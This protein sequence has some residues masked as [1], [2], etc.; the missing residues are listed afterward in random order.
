MA[1]THTPNIPKTVVTVTANPNEFQ[2]YPVDLLRGLKGLGKAIIDDD[3]LYTAVQAFHESATE[4]SA[5]GV[6]G[7]ALL[8]KDP[9]IVVTSATVHAVPDD[10]GKPAPPPRDE[11]GEDGGADGWDAYDLHGLLALVKQHKVQVDG[12][13]KT[14]GKLIA[15]LEAAGV[16]P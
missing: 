4:G 8:T 14:P 16:Q 10:I 15:A 6:L 2:G 13:V 11:D 5:L 1:P 12:R 9:T 7:P 3:A